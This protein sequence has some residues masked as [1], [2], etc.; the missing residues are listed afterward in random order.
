MQRCRTWYS[1]ASTPRLLEIGSAAVNGSYSD[2]FADCGEYIVFDVQ[3]GPGVDVVLDDPYVLP[4]P[5]KSVDLVISGQMLEHCPQFWRVFSEIARIL[6]P[7]G[8]LFMIAP[9]AGPI[10]LY[11]VDCYRF[12][13]DAYQALADWSGLRLEDCWMDERG[14]W[15]DLVGV[16]QKGG[17]RSVQPDFGW[18]YR[19]RR[20]SA[21][22][23]IGAA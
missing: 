8:V 19:P 1:P 23:K 3:S 14:P 12:Y 21:A 10:H 11:P 16:F 7:E 6:K 17:L 2:I 13:P 20:C 9:S 18:T 4:L 22:D 15:R 5:E